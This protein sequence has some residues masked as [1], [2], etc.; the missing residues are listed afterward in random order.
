MALVPFPTSSQAATRTAAI[1]KL[2][3]RVS[4][5]S[6]AD[7]ATVAEL[8]EVAASVISEYAPGAPQ[9]IKDEAAIRYVGYINQAPPGSIQKIELKDIS[10]EYRQAPPASS[11]QLSGAKALLTR[12][13]I[14]RAGAIG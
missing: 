3:R 12:W 9:A 4:G 5:L 6:S 7:D 1:A 11:F 8:G 2:K 14:R 13:K 10:I